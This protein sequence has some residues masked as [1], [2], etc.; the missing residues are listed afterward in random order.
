M[1]KTKKR[2]F[3]SFEI[4]A[5]ISAMLIYIGLLPLKDNNPFV[6]VAELSSINEIF[7]YVYSNP[8]KTAKG[9]SYIFEIETVKVFDEKNIENKASGCLKI[10]CPSE[11]LESHY[12]GKLYDKFG[13]VVEKGAFL[14]LKNIRLLD[15]VEEKSNPFFYCEN[16]ESMGWKNILSAFRGKMRMQFKRL[17]FQWGNA[18]GLLLALL[19]G[20]REYTN[21]AL[22]DGFQKSGLSHILALSGMHLSFFSLMAGNASKKL[23]GKK[24]V[25]IFSLIAI[26]LFVWFAGLSPSLFRALLCSL[27][28]MILFYVNIDFSMFTILSVSF[29]IQGIIS[30]GDVKTLPFILSYCAILGI[31]LFGDFFMKYF[32][33][34]FPP[35]IASSISSSCGAILCTSPITLYFFGTFAPIGIIATVVVAPLITFYLMIGFIFTLIVLLCPPFLVPLGVLLNLLYNIIDFIVCLFAKVPLLSI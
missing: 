3:S 11:V 14:K 16:I 2:F 7:G 33:K 20:S 12:P 35:S 23:F 22:A 29:V 28:S 19:S 15:F 10:L 18:G 8:V 13:T 21:K 31:V 9:S 26:V 1:I 30:P 34:I 6:S 4:V 25:P 32:I 27:I 5:I 17:M 24:I